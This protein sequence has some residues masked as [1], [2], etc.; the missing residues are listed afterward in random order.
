MNEKNYFFYLNTVIQTE[1]HLIEA[2]VERIKFSL[3]SLRDIIE[4]FDKVFIQEGEK[5]E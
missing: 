3:E 4:K 5:Q 1:M 2:E